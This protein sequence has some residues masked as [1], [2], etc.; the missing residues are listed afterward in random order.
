MPYTTWYTWDKY[1]SNLYLPVLILLWGKSISQGVIMGDLASEPCKIH[2][3]MWMLIDCFHQIVHQDSKTLAL[4]CKHS[5][6]FPVFHHSSASVYY[7]ERKLKNTKHGW[8]LGMRQHN[9]MDSKWL[10]LMTIPFLQHIPVYT[11]CQLS[12]LLPE[13]KHAI[14]R[15][16][17]SKPF[18]LWEAASSI[19]QH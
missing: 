11:K 2:S 16:L 14:K 12:V 15:Q 1:K 4:Y 13:G 6:A 8:G 9:I 19:F 17:H 10:V 7:T 5:Q 18:T 3:I